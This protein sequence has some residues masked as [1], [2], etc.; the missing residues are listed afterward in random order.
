[1]SSRKT[2]NL[3]TPL[4]RIASILLLFVALF[5]TTGCHMMKT[6]SVELPVDATANAPMYQIQMVSMMGRADVSKRVIK[7]K[8]TVQDALEEAGAIKK[9]RGMRITLSRL[10]DKNGQVL[11]LPVDY[12]VSKRAVRPEQNYSLHPGDTL[13]ISAASDNSMDKI[14]GA[15]TG[16]AL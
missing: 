10:L 5:A 2:Q 15:L 4:T 14:I 16:G 13:T 6:S 3:A 7:D 11:K 8:M 12:Q 9:Y 1:M